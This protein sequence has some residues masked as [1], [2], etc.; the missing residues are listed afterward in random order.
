MRISTAGLIALALTVNAPSFAAVLAP[1]EIGGSAAPATGQAFGAWRSAVSG[2]ATALQVDP[3]LGA[4]VPNLAPILG[5]VRL[6]LALKPRSEPALAFAAYLPAGAASDPAAF[7][8]MPLERRVRA[9]GAAVAA[10]SAEL[11]PRADELIALSAR[12]RL[13]MWER[14]E[15][16]AAAARWFYL[17]PET[18]EAVK[19]AAAEA[20]GDAALGLAERIAGALP[21]GIRRTPEEKA[22]RAELIQVLKGAAAIVAENKTSPGAGLVSERLAPYVARALDESDARVRER[23]GLEGRLYAPILEKQAQVFG[24]D[25]DRTLFKTLRS[26]GE[27]TEFVSAATLHAAERLKAMGQTTR[28]G[29]ALAAEG[30]DLRLPIPAWH[31]LFG[32][33]PSIAHWLADV[34]GRPEARR[35]RWDIPLFT[36]FGIPVSAK[37]SF[38]PAFALGVYQFGMMF[39]HAHRSL[40]LGVGMLDGLAAALLLYVSVLAH[41]FGHVAAAR[42]F[43]IRTSYVVL[44]LLGG[45][46]AVVRGFRQ[47]L[48]EFVIALAGPVTSALAGVAF[49]A[50]A[51][52]FGSTLTGGLFAM[53]GMI[54][55]LLA[56]YN[57]FPLFPMD[58]GRIMR[59]GLTRLFGSYRATRLAGA[60][61]FV[62]S[63]LL[64]GY[65]LMAARTSLLM[66]GTGAL[67]GVFFSVISVIMSAH[68]GTVTVDERPS[69]KS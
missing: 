53:V 21:F 56:G 43:G 61:S 31:P 46:A 24:R 29:L 4:D 8:R 23:I 33:Y 16:D 37:R 6:E 49:S 66:G 13:S 15:L 1:V 47:A 64:F 67:F 7:A 11:Q 35:E 55:F 52:A 41:E 32:R 48:P 25:A 36:A 54:N 45:G 44:T 17:A 10:A 19:K 51:F 50:A 39:F 40:G 68:P 62:L 42:A 69:A 27:W 14:A 2:V 12:G 38:L 20:H 57:L 28:R 65:G 30:D 63:N 58:G 26:R 3:S 5:R 9:L 22:V 60:I 18:A 59:A 34:Q